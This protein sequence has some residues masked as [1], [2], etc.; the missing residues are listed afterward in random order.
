MAAKL[1]STFGEELTHWIA[2]SRLSNL[3]YTPVAAMKKACRRVSMIIKTVLRHFV[4][5]DWVVALKMRFA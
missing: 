4:D 5:V 1:L 2:I 3:N